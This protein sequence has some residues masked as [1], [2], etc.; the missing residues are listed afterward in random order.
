[1]SKRLTQKEL[2]ALKAAVYGCNT[3]KKCGSNATFVVF[4]RTDKSSINIKEEIPY[5]DALEIMFNFIEQ[6]EKNEQTNND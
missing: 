1:M 5:S 4:D 2:L 6:E 3:N